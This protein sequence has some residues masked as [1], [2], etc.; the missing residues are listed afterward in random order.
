M[1]FLLRFVSFIT[2]KVLIIS[3]VSVLAFYAF[4]TGMN[5]TNIY[6]VLKDGM[7]TRA[8]V[9]LNRT[10]AEELSKFF[11][12]D[13][14]AADSIYRDKSYDIYTIRGF[15][16]ALNI[17]RM[18]CWPW[19]TTASATITEYILR[20]D[21]ELPVE[22]QTEEQ[23]KSKNKIPP[24]EWKNARY[25][26]ILVQEDGQWLIGDLRLVESL[27][28]P[29]PT[30][31]RPTP[32]FFPTATPYPTATPNAIAVSGRGESPTPTATKKPT[33][34]PKATATRRP[35]STPRRTATP[36]PTAR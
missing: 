35:T 36:R 5:M 13:Y 1:T 12:V 28:A 21:G 15:E 27:P 31:A 10:S 18:W 23:K 11:D 8:G 33:P 7:E 26:V 25:S 24:P 34:T 30:P 3:I 19:G 20:I 2:R 32:R 16:H 4:F 29:T 6:I 14:L 9:V 17:E 22:R